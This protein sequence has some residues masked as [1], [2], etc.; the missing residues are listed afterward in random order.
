[1]YDIDC[2][3]FLANDY[4]TV[5]PLKMKSSD[6]PQM[7]TYIY[8]YL[9][10]S[11]SILDIIEN[12]TQRFE[13]VYI[14]VCSI[15][16]HVYIYMNVVLGVRVRNTYLISSNRWR[17]RFEATFPILNSKFKTTRHSTAT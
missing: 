1:M 6:E 2:L 8:I 13:H 5:Y 4:M 11:R 15:A 17:E 16:D 12:F 3:S 10:L 14:Q 9:V 7:N